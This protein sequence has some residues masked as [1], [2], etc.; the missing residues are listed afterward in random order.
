MHGFLARAATVKE[1]GLDPETTLIMGGSALAL[2]GIRPAGDL[3]L[4]IPE[5]LFTGVARNR[6]TPG[7]ISLQYK[8]RTIYPVLT[9][10]KRP[11]GTMDVDITPPTRDYGDDG[12]F[13]EELNQY[14]TFEGYRFLSPALV[15]ARKMRG[16]DQRRSKDIKDVDLI[17]RHLEE[18]GRHNQ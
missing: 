14:D 13:L 2:A 12:T 17:R 7:G 6:A 16:G 15:A 9:T 18:L 11:K 8:P 10:Y 3:D 5:Y 1:T 4:I